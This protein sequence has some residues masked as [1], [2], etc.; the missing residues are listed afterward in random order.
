MNL[1]GYWIEPVSSLIKANVFFWRPSY[2]PFGGLIYRAVFAMFGFNPRPLYVVYFAAMLVNLWLA[3]LLLKRIGGSA[4]IAAIGVLL[5]EFHG[6]LDY[7]YYNAGSMYDVFCFL[8]FSLA[9]LIYLPV[10]IQGRLLGIRGNFGF[11][12]CFICALNSKEMAATLP[13]I[14]LVYELTFHPPNLRGTRAFIAWC[15]HDGRTALLAAVCVLIYLPSKLGPGGLG[16]YVGYIPSYTWGRWL[17][18]T[19]TYLAYVI[20][21]NNPASDLGVTPLAPAE[22]G[23]SYGLLIAIALWVRSREVW[24]G[25]LFFVITLLPVSFIDP[26]LGS[27]LYLPLVGLALACAVCLVRFKEVL[28][29]RFSV[30]M[31]GHTL[32]MHI[33]LSPRS[34]SVVMFVATALVMTIVDYQHWPR[35]LNARYS[36]YKK[37][38]DELS[39]LYPSLPHGSK[40][41][42]VH[43]PVND[44]WGLLFLLR[45]YYRDADLF[46]TQLDGPRQQ[47]ISIDQLPH[48]DHV[49]DF[50][51]GHYIE[52]DNHDVPLSV[53]LRIAKA[54]TRSSFSGDVMIIGT[55]AA[56]EHIVKGVL[57]TDPKA[58]GY[59]TLDQTELRFRLS[60]VEHRVFREHFYLPLDT[61]KRTG[62]LIVDFYVNGHLLDHTRFAKDGELVYQHEVPVAWLRTGS[63]TTAIMRIHNPYIAR[64][65]GAR[66]GVVLR[67]AA[68]V[69]ATVPAH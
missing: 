14:V 41:L 69:P 68:F 58:D 55:P 61:F 17:Q 35:A 2:R 15:F 8:F 43:S 42:F 5:C 63:P 21:R 52:L 56:A 50:E 29:H 3:Y 27:V 9:L 38:V 36:P 10:R 62:P 34:A 19:G 12:A 44:D 67:S 47:R 23:L 39:H 20:Y 11:F 1:Y 30:G 4:E 7:L 53:Q 40:I 24:F 13:I 49:F 16:H 25:L 26:R 46:L 66:L 31:R 28:W 57:V 22:V 59:W 65:D 33:S 48:Y 45:L 18:D 6:K 54:E 37:T 60:S 64:R 51:N 32:P